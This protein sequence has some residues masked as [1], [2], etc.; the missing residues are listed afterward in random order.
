MSFLSALLSPYKGAAWTIALKIILSKVHLAGTVKVGWR[1]TPL[2]VPTVSDKILPVRE[3]SSGPSA[4]GLLPTLFTAFSQFGFYTHLSSPKCHS[5]PSWFPR[6]PNVLLE[7][8]SKGPKVLWQEA[9]FPDP[10][11]GNFVLGAVTGSDMGPLP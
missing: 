3:Q 6:H 11:H 10:P 7:Q 4:Q 5:G 1:L 9:A 8:C 2:A